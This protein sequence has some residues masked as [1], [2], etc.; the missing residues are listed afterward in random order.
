MLSS[1][2]F[3][4]K[5]WEWRNFPIELDLNAIRNRTEE[6]AI[7]APGFSA[8]WAMHEGHAGLI[9]LKGTIEY[10]THLDV[11]NNQISLSQYPL[12][13]FSTVGSSNLGADLWSQQT[14]Y[15]ELGIGAFKLLLSPDKDRCIAERVEYM[16]VNVLRLCEVFDWDTDD[17]FGRMLEDSMFPII[18]MM[19]LK[20][21]MNGH[22]L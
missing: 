9:T 16:K 4:M 11:L 3:N 14:P 17:M 21:L 13:Q 15:N 2:R 20:E 18:S 19:C 6:L 12:L 10:A 7:T 5:Q 1:V 8:Q 22:F